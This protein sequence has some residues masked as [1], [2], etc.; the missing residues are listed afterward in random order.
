MPQGARIQLGDL[1]TLDID[2]V[3]SPSFLGT[4]G[5]VQ[6]T[7]LQVWEILEQRTQPS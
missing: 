1:A 6:A 3:L 4:W 5:H 2:L 7:V